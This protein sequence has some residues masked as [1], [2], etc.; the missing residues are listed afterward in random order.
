MSDEEKAKG[1]L[2][3]VEGGTFMMG[4]TEEQGDDSSGDEKP[5]RL[6]TLSD[7]RISNYP[8]TQFQWASLMGYNPSQYGG[9]DSPVEGVS[10][11][12]AQEFIAKLKELSGMAL[13]LPTEA[14][15]EYAA[16]GG[17]RSKGYKYSGSNNIDEVAWYWD[18]SGGIEYGVRPIGTK[19]P[20]ELGLYD[21]C[22]NV[23][24]WVSDWYGED[25]YRSAPQTNPQGPETGECRVL[26]GGW[27]G[28]KQGGCRVSSRGNLYPDAQFNFLGF[29][30][31]LTV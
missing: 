31:A 18:N 23:W 16:R 22:G 13:R 20:N 25:Y 17:N 5:A 28:Y 1:G 24:E 29:R 27:W 26:R 2:I 8:V 11:D 3:L 12:A 6:V 7:F 9:D 30:L 14:E 4:A 15:W 10:W 19:A 21:M